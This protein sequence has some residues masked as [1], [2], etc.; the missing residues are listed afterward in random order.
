MMM[1]SVLCLM[2][3][4]V[5]LCAPAVARSGKDGDKHPVLHSLVDM[6]TEFVQDKLE[7]RRQRKNEEAAA[8]AADA[9]A[10]GGAVASK[11]GA[12]L[13]PTSKLIYQVVDE[14]LGNKISEALDHYKEEGRNYARQLGDVVAQRILADKK[15]QSSIEL[16]KIL[17]GV[18]VA[19]LT[20]VT[21]AL[22]KGL[23]SIKK[24][25]ER[26]LVLLQELSRRQQLK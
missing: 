23:R 5:G 12:P 20:L 11:V 7:K 8:K 15:V 16:L 4:A 13:P 24:S 19:Y 14:V 9:S 25:N 26:I 10:E 3:L 6:G 21:L 17:V 2:L 1:K 18:I 22:L